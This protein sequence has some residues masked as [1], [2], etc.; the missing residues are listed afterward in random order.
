M[1]TLKHIALFLLPALAVA[2]FS[3]CGTTTS[4]GNL[5]A[6]LASFVQ[7]IPS[8][9]VTDASLQVST[10]LWSHQLSVTGLSKSTSGQVTITNLK[11]N[12]AIPLCGF[13][14]TFSVSG[15]TF[16]AGTAPL[17]P[18]VALVAK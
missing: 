7:S 5:G 1:K 6:E 17:A 3:G 16:D 10:P 11:D 13:T 9:T 15:L 4:K 12:F 18:P 8:N 2:L 14:K